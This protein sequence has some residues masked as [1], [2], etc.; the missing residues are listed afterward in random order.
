MSDPI[1]IENVATAQMWFVR[2][3]RAFTAPYT[4]E[5]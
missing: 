4:C 3:V 5:L 2:V 1:S